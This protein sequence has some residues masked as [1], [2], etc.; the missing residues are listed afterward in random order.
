[1]RSCAYR[2]PQA[3]SGLFPAARSSTLEVILTSSPE[4]VTPRDR[5][6]IRAALV[7]LSRAVNILILTG[8][9]MPSADSAAA[10]WAKS[11]FNL[12]SKFGST[13]FESAGN[14][15]ALAGVAAADN[16]GAFVTLVK[17]GR[18]PTAASPVTRAALE[19]YARVFFLLN[20]ESA[21]VFYHRYLSLTH[22]ELKYPVRYSKFANASGEEI[23]G[24]AYR[25]ELGEINKRLGFN[26]FLDVGLAN[27]VGSLLANSL[28]EP[29]VDPAIYSQ[30]S[31]VAHAASSA[32]GMFLKTTSTGWQLIL[33]RD[34]A[35]EYCGYL[36]SA[37]VNVAERIVVAFRPTGGAVDRWN[38]ARARAEVALAEL[39]I[40]A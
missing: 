38:A 24:L 31:G 5:E 1:M 16:V 25:R 21:E 12:P 17:S 9:G 28:E 23:D 6:L 36:Y 13:L 22:E 34:V 27:L 11:T 14:A 8:M 20:A 18:G 3:P 39:Q 15:I 30:L 35:L 32:I 19:A 10:F 37:A 29:D 26:D 2:S 4:P 40:S 7:E 33:P